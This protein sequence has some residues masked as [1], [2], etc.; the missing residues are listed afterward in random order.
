MTRDRKKCFISTIEK[1]IEDL[2]ADIQRMKSTLGEVSHTKQLQFV[3]PATSPELQPVKSPSLVHDDD[4]SSL[5]S[6]ADDSQ[7]PVKRVR[8]GF[9]LGE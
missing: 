4:E 1:T 9:S 3:T 8:H 5:Y 2:E 7:H 6:A